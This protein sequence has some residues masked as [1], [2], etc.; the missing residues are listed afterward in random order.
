MVILFKNLLPYLHKPATTDFTLYQEEITGF[1]Q[2]LSQISG[3]PFYRTG[4][5]NEKDN[6]VT[7]HKQINRTGEYPLQGTNELGTEYDR[8][9]TSGKNFVQNETSQKILINLNLS[10]SLDLIIIRGV[11]PF[12]SRRIIKYR[13]LVG[14]FVRK[15]QLLE[16]YGISKENYDLISSQV[17]IDTTG[18]RYIGLNTAAFD[19]LRRH[20]YLDDYQARAIISFR[21]VNGRFVYARQLVEENILPEETFNKISGYLKID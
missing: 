1:E 3:E 21:N 11:G 16:V 13:Y 17:Y 10:D 14:G 12:L 8:S 18:I 7:G 5:N 9:E 20:P 19:V 6:T 2:S 4:D 15:D